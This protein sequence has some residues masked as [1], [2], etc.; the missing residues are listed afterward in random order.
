M[1]EK[2][3]LAIVAIA[4]GV[5]GWFFTD[6]MTWLFGQVELPLPSSLSLDTIATGGVTAI[7][8]GALVWLVKHWQSVTLPDMVKESKAALAEQRADFLADSK[9]MREQFTTALKQQQDDCRVE[10]DRIHA[11]WQRVMDRY[12]GTNKP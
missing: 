9:Q 10:Q 11:N 5:T 7:A 1:A 2:I 12:T 6:A 4:S 3:I 8:I